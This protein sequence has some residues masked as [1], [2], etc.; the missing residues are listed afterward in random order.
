MK[1][2]FL[3]S[4][5]AGALSLPAAAD[6]GLELRLNDG[7]AL[8][9]PRFDQREVDISV[10]GRLDEPQ[11]AQ[12]PV[13]EAFRVIEPESLQEPAYRTRLRMFY[14][15]RGLYVS[16][17][18]EQPSD[19]IIQRLSQRDDGGLNRDSVS[20]TLD[21]S[22]TGRYGYWM[23]LAL[24]NNQIDG[25]ILPERQYSRDWDGAWYGGT[26][27]HERGWSAEFFVPWSQMAMPQEGERRTIGMYASRKV[28]HLD[29]RWAWPPLP[30]SRARF[31]SDLQPLVLEAVNPKQQWSLF[32][33]TSMTL[34]RVAEDARYKA[35]F[36]VFWRP[37][38]N[39]QVTATVNPDF[40]NVESDD[41]IVNLSALETF[42][43]EKR[44]FFL[45]GQ[46]VFVAAPRARWD[47][48][49]TLV[50]T[51]RIGGPARPLALEGDVSFPVQEL[52]QPSELFGA[53][54]A[55]GQTGTLRYGLLA[56]AE[57][58]VKLYATDGRRFVQDGRDFGVARLL[59]EANDGGA[60]RAFG[61]LGTV[62]A[63]ADGDA[64]VNG[65]DFHAL[66]ADGRWKYDGQLMASD[67]D[68]VGRGY[69]GF[70]DVQH[71]PRS[72]LRYTANLAHYDDGLQINDLGYLARNDA[73]D[74]R[75]GL[76]WVASPGG[77]V[78]DFEIKP[79]LR[80]QRNG[81]GL[82]TRAGIG[83]RFELT[84]DGLD[85][86]ESRVAFYPA[87]YEDL[88][89]FGNGTY[90]I[91]PRPALSLLYRTDTSR[92]LSLFVETDYQGDG[93]DG[94]HWRHRAGLDWR[95]VD[96]LNLHVESAY[97]RRDGWLLHQEAR[98]MTAFGAE[99]WQPKVNLDFFLSARQQFRLAFQWVGIKA[100]E[101]RFYQVPADPGDLV[102]TARPDDVP[103]DFTVSQLNVQMRYRWQIAPLSDLFLVY[104]RNGLGGADD[105][106]F[107]DLVSTAWQ[108]PIGDQ[109]VLKLRYRLGS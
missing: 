58:D 93:I 46:E 100:A 44:L 96:R 66:T 89:S 97:A 20:F 83:S 103:D 61:W 95:P 85:R 60:Y 41:V 35:G 71:T 42:Y 52:G 23:N 12:A 94:Y 1:R 57:E 108:E 3:W 88:N 80:Y 91:E 68:G 98:N 4:A 37:S 15:D 75:L 32:P 109:L 18:N 105:R 28:A 29:Q 106:S 49:V 63:H 56:A 65:V 81:E 90:R 19:T 69:G 5:I 82:M 51:R 8:V 16:F 54:K 30:R 47:D 107:G 9:L 14:T 13:V 2:L 34:D 64:V 101:Q 79:F 73:T 11:W 59:H 92:P 24:G 104:T 26:T 87:R 6:D 77:L 40:G 48:P 62:T 50:N 43:P 45:E 72:G 7:G 27:R 86:I 33:F 102:E 25:T 55:T 10:D 74:V 21:T 84:L 67:V 39:F 17:D 31:M 99:E 78:R 36:D 70:V 53:V 22:G 76:D 38:S